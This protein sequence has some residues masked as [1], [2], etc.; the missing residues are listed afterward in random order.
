[1]LYYIL[2]AIGACGTLGSVLVG[3]LALADNNFGMLAGSSVAM[4]LFMLL[5]LVP[6][7]IKRGREQL[8]IYKYYKEKYYEEVEGKN[9]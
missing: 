9:K 1:M 4:W 2:I 3:F 7:A 8:K 6:I 5:W